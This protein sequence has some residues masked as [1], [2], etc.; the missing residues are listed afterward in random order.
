MRD[1]PLP[2]KMQVRT[3]E[4]R[5]HAVK[6]TRPSAPH[7]SPSRGP[8]R[9]LGSRDMAPRCGPST[10]VPTSVRCSTVACSTHRAILN[11]DTGGACKDNRLEEELCNPE[12]PRLYIDVNQ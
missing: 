11:I 3:L 8:H 7:Q 12:M 6:T 9:L 10:A 4:F 1:A 5:L 2:Q